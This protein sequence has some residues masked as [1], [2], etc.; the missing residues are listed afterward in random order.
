MFPFKRG[1]DFDRSDLVSSP[2]L[3]KQRVRGAWSC[4]VSTRLSWGGAASAKAGR[5]SQ[6]LGLDRA[7]SAAAACK[8]CRVGHPSSSA[9]EVSCAAWGLAPEQDT[10]FSLDL[11]GSSK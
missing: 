7:R 5:C 9:S 11:Q 2:S 3:A 1:S 10:A 6:A 8:A 4:D